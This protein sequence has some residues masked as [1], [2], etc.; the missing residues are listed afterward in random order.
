MD[1]RDFLAEIDRQTE[2]GLAVHVICDNL[3]AHK[4]PVVHKWLLAH[5]R[6]TLHL[7]PTYSSAWINQVERW[8]AE[9][10][11]RCLERGVFCS[12]DGL[13]TALGE[14]IKIWNAAAMPFKWTKTRPP[15]R[16]ATTARGSPDRLTGRCAAASVPPSSGRG[17]RIHRRRPLAQPRSLRPMA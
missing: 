14:W 11:R 1:F 12:L 10:Q 3:S 9:L 13:K 17:I 4:T 5:S 8:F 15:T 7:T 6:F 16:S 2:P